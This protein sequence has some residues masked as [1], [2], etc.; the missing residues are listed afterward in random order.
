VFLIIHVTPGDPVDLILGETAE[1]VAWLTQLTSDNGLADRVKVLQP[2][3]TFVVPE[4]ISG[5][6][7]AHRPQ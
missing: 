4:R 3:Q 5:V 2:G 1:P 7:G 6:S